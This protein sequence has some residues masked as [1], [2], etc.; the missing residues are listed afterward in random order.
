M[1]EVKKETQLKKSKK[2]NKVASLLLA[3]ALILTCG[4]AGTIAQYQKSLGGNATATVAKFDVSAT[5]LGD[6]Q[7]TTLDLFNDVKNIDGNAEAHV[8]QDTDGKVKLIAPGT[9]G[10]L[11][12]SFTNKSEV[13][14]NCT[15]KIELTSNTGVISTYKKADGTTVAAGGTIPLKFALSTEANIADVVSGDWKDITD[16]GNLNNLSYTNVKPSPTATKLYLHWKW[17]NDSGNNDLDTAI[18]EIMQY[19]GYDA[20]NIK[21]ASNPNKAV[22][23]NASTVSSKGLTLPTSAVNGATF[24]LPQ[25][26]ITAT[27]EQ[28]TN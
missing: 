28:T 14:V 7:K 6:P 11:D 4:V 13:D 3:L 17:E 24:T 5:N 20:T 19:L 1:E 9:S 15:M 26:T 10:V 22:V 8:N 18:G 27:F 2:K 12:V 21:D 23:P 25:V 16:L